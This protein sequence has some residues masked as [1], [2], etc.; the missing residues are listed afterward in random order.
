M[1]ATMSSADDLGLPTAFLTLRYHPFDHCKGQD[2]ATSLA[3]RSVLPPGVHAAAAA[4]GAQQQAVQ[5]TAH[6]RTA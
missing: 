3:V 4:L 1:H 5:Y 2:P 6:T